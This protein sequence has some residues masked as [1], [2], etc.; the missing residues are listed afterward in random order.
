M[1]FRRKRQ[2]ISIASVLLSTVFIGTLYQNCSKTQI[3]IEDMEAAARALEAER[4]ALGMDEETVTAGLHS[5][6]N[7]K[8]FFVVDNSGTMKE[9]Q[10]NLSASF[11][12]MFD[13]NSADSLSK[14]DTTSYLFSTAQRSPSLSSERSLLDQIY[15]KQKNFNEATAISGVDFNSLYRSS[16]QNSG[17]VPGDNIGFHLTY[18]QN[19]SKYQFDLAPVLGASALSSGLIGWNRSIHKAAA[20]N[21]L[22]ME[23]EFKERLKILDAER[24]PL[25]NI[26]GKYA[27]EHSSIVD[28]ESGLCAV[29]RIL[30]NPNSYVKSGDLLSFIIVS[31]END[32]DPNGYNCI[33]SYTEYTGAE[34]LVDGLCKRNETTL[35]YKT[36]T[37]TKAPD[38]CNLNGTKGYKFQV[39]YPN[40]RYTTTVTYK[41][42]ITPAK[43]TVPLTTLTYQAQTTSYKYLNTNITYYYETCADVISDGLV[44]GTKCTINTT[45]VKATKSGDYTADCYALAKSLNTKAVNVAGYAPVCTTSYNTVSSC[46]KLDPKCQVTVA[47]SNKVISNLL[48][49]YSA[50]ACLTKAQSYADFASGTTPTCVGSSKIVTSCTAEQIAAGCIKT[51]EAT[52]GPKTGTASSDLTT[53]ATGCYDWA[54]TQ[55]NNAVSS[56]SD[57]TTCQKNTIN[58]LLTY[59]SSLTFAETQSAD[60]GTTLPVGDCGAIKNLAINKAKVAKPQI[61]QNDACSITGYDN[62]AQTSALLVSDCTTQAQARCTS[63]SL[64]SCSGTLVVGATS[65]TVSGPISFKKIPEK[66]SCASKCSDSI[67]GACDSESSSNQTIAEYIQKLHGPTAA[68][69]ASVSALS[70]VASTHT[71]VLMSEESN[72]CKPS[73]EGI[74]TYFTRTKGPYRMNATEIDYVAGSVKDS[75]GIPRP[76]TD[77][78]TYIKTRSAELSQISPIFATIVRMPTDPLGLGGSAGLE[79][80]KLIN[81]GSSGQAE[82]VLSTDYSIVLKD[83]GK[84]LKTKLERSFVLQKMKP[85]QIITRVLLNPKGSQAEIEIPQSQWTQSGATLTLG[86]DLDFNDGDTFRVEFQNYLK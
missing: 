65:T 83:L 71:A 35:T 59:S 66:L 78:V 16:T 77:L 46:D 10:L 80:L 11:G 27:P 48:G 21:P 56:L 81:N 1:I 55:S 38:S 39:K 75:S 9:N 51:A 29:A 63:E 18:S 72:I 28:S 32:A 64:R 58:E 76:K 22:Q 42:L 60:A 20:D 50:S 69:S 33:Q 73:L 57:I 37:T 13:Q 54:K 7:L 49:S 53:T 36:S 34:D 86:A 79:Y 82:S 84:V 31:D 70:E 19:P 26:N 40:T 8:M 15:T 74:P 44:T 43:Y 4:L 24:I 2:L 85:H 6:P 23:N 25:V 12:A 41:A 17:L 3:A 45:P 52:Y 14:F 62:A 47:L 61:T 68:C 30:R 67:L 5:V